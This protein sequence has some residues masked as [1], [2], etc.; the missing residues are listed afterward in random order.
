MVQVMEAW[1]IADV[2]AL[3]RYY[4]IGFKRNAIPHNENVEQVE[5]KIL[6]KALNTATGRTKKRKYHKI[7]HAP[8]ILK[9][10]DAEKACD[11]APHCNLLFQTLSQVIAG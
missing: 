9:V 8:D 2:D 11:A 3:E 10:I 1:L 5:W 7:Q 6:E 4:G